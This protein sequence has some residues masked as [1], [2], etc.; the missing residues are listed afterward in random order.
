MKN[1]IENIQKY[2][3]NIILTKKIKYKEKEMSPDQ[4][5]DFI[6]FEKR[7]NLNMIGYTIFLIRIQ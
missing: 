5:Q 1:N 2:E 6:L 4:M 7:S 3:I